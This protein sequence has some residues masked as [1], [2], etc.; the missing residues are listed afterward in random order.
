MLAV[1]SKRANWEKEGAWFCPALS[2][3]DWRFYYV[4]IKAYLN[5]G[6]NEV[7]WL[8]NIVG[9]VA[10]SS[11]AAYFIGLDISAFTAIIAVCLFIGS[12]VLGFLVL[13]GF[14]ITQFEVDFQN[15]LHNGVKIK[16]R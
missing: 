13:E 8:K 14:R 10:Y 6:I 3:K 15:S 12:F 9:F 7:A 2:S 16:W 1:K 4:R 5:A 11:A